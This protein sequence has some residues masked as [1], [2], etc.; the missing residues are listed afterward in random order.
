M[1]GRKC[2]L[3]HH[4]H[5]VRHEPTNTWACPRCDQIDKAPTAQRKEW[6]YP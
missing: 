1:K 4:Q 6:A 2:G 5:L 3:C